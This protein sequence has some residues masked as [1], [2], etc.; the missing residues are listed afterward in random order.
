[1]AEVMMK[2]TRGRVDDSEQIHTNG[3]RTSYSTVTADTT[4]ASSIEKRLPTVTQ[5]Q[6]KGYWK[7]E[8]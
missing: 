1:M 6:R 7:N 4:E 2:R 3:W 5:A 8:G